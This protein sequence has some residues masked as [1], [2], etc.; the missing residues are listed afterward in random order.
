MTIIN[1]F[2]NSGVSHSNPKAATDYLYDV[3][4]ALTDEQKLNYSR[5][6]EE[7]KLALLSNDPVLEHFA[8]LAQQEKREIKPKKRT[9]PPEAIS[10][11]R[12]TVEYAIANCGF[13]HKYVSGVIAHAHED[14]EK[15]IQN[16]EIEREWRELFEELCFAGLPKD[17]RLIDWIRHTHQGNIENHFLIPRIHL[18]SGKSFN[19]AYPGHERDFNVLRDYLN[20]KYDL[21]D[22]TDPSR[23]RLNNSG[24]ASDKTYRIKA[25]LGK[26]VIKLIEMEKVQCRNDVVGLLNRKV[27]QDEYGI[28]TVST[29]DNFV[30]IEVEGRKTAIRLKGFAFSKAFTS[31][32]SIRQADPSI[33][34]KDERL[35][36]LK[37]QLTE[38]IEKRA[39]FNTERYGSST[40]IRSERSKEG[41]DTEFKERI[42]RPLSLENSVSVSFEPIPDMDPN[43]KGW[44]RAVQLELRRF[45]AHLNALKALELRFARERKQLQE[46]YKLLHKDTYEPDRKA[47]GRHFEHLHSRA[48]NPDTSI[49][50]P[51]RET[52]RALRN[53]HQAI[54]ERVSAGTDLYT[55]QDREYTY[56][57]DVG[58]PSLRRRVNETIQGIRQAINI[59]ND[60][61]EEV[62]TQI[63]HAG[64]L[65]ERSSE[66]RRQ[67]DRAFKHITQDDMLRTK[68]KQRMAQN[69]RQSKQ[70][71]VKKA[72]QR[73]KFINQLESSGSY[74]V[75]RPILD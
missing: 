13:K 58:I 18:R 73:E 56:K 46:L 22:P 64:R 41:V 72:L 60:C 20:M 43:L 40:K 53:H 51:G 17:E 6:T 50:R 61:S 26:L 69:Q 19:P 30:R 57:N 54:N 75:S 55:G 4:C 71:E 37:Q 52:I 2:R 33:K 32:A 25:R 39:S 7:I 12:S 49:T 36:E 27:L 44:Q 65:A 35:A 34:T 16:P 3:Y 74:T 8:K 59:S 67:L 21:A 68:L 11:N 45:I 28:Q 23:R 14:T 63:R 5:L 24:R 10:G 15:L 29:S 42:D 9:P 1:I 31:L 66:I 70:N 62:Q 48:T 47:I 38:C